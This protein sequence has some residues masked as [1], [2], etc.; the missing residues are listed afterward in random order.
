MKQKSPRSLNSLPNAKGKYCANKTE[1]S[2]TMDDKQ[3]YNINY[4]KEQKMLNL[5]IKKL[6]E[7]IIEI[8]KRKSNIQRRVSSL[9]K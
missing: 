4:H 5:D 9:S 1:Q 8:K 2:V 7:Q 6:K 3:S